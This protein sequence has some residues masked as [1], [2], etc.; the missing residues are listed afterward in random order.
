MRGSFI[1]ESAE[2]FVRKEVVLG[3]DYRVYQEVAEQAA[4]GA[5]LLLME[6]FGKVDSREKAPGDLVTEADLASQRQIAEVLAQSFPDHTLM[7]EEDGVVPD[8]DCPWRWI[9]DPLDGTANFAHAMPLWCVSIALEHAGDLV[10]GVVHMP[11]LSTTYSAASGQGLTVNGQAGRVSRAETLRQSLIAG[12]L[13]VDFA[14]HAE[15]ELAIFGRFSSG[16]HSARRTG[17]TAWNLALVASGA[18]EVAYG[19]SVHPWD[20]AAGFVLV[21]EGG[22]T[23]SGLIGEPADVYSPGFL[24]TNGHVHAE[25]L[26]A[27]AEAFEK[28]NEE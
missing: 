3:E 9:V 2:P 23:I 25:A 1:G 6:A 15:R 27:L 28:A 13:P 8:P 22:G 19:T 20:I 11:T 4:L 14:K 18:S 10:V 7:A 5:G 24:A 17:T 26:Q 12:A 16:T 21:R